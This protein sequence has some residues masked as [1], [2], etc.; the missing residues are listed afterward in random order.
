MADSDNFK[1]TPAIVRL[2]VLGYELNSKQNACF[3]YLL[4]AIFWC[5]MYILHFASDLVLAH[6]HHIEEDP[7]WASLTLFFMYL[8]VIGCFVLTVSSIEMWPDYDECTLSNVKWLSVKILQHLF[9]PIWTMWR[10][11]E[12]IFWAIEGYRAPTEDDRQECLRKSSAPRSIEFYFFL[13]GFLHTIPQILLQLHI[14]M[15]NVKLLDQQTIDMQVA[16]MVFNLATM[17][18]T[19]VQ[20]QR[21]KSQKMGGKNYPWY[22]P[23]KYHD[24]VDAALLLP[25]TG[26]IYCTKENY[27]KIANDIEERRIKE[28]EENAGDDESISSS[29]YYLEPHVDE[30]DFPK[31]IRQIYAL[32]EDDLAGKVLAFFW[33]FCF[34]LARFLAISTFAYFFPKDII[35]LLSSHFILCVS[36]LLYDARAYLVRRTKAVF[37]IFVGLIYL[38]CIIEFK[39][40]FTRVRFIYNGYFTLVFS[41]NFIMCLIWWFSRMDDT[42]LVNDWWFRYIFYMTLLCTFLSLSSMIVYKLTRQSKVVVGQETICD[43]TI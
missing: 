17:A 20:Y 23:Y 18:A 19:T 7:I 34:L 27:Q 32:P 36:F 29:V 26:I 37:F 10:Y 21:F 30:V 24:N 9:F 14:L 41:E 2:T 16:S 25:A 8:P 31:A 28:I 43:T 35:W 15:R 11:A 5:S 22:K 33:W 39:K 40:Q 38:F 13:K 12:K 3:N 4:P 1:A 42:G 6:R